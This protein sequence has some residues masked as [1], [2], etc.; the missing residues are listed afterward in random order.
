MEIVYRYFIGEIEM[1]ISIVVPGHDRE[2]A[3]KAAEEIMME[4]GFEYPYDHMISF[5]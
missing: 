2:T 3:V 5:R 1:E 4:K